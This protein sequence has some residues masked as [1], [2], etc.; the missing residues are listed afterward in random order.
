[1]DTAPHLSPAARAL[2]A[3]RLVVFDCDGVL[4]DTERIGPKVVAEMATEAG[5]PLTPAEV[6]EKFLGTSEPYLLAQVRAHATAP[7]PD[8]WLVEYRSRVAAAFDAAP[9]TMPGVVE[10]LDALDARS[11]PYCVA[12]SGSHPRIRHSLTATGLWERFAGRVF[13][14]D[15]VHRGKPAPDLFLHAAAACGVPPG[16][17]LVIEDSPAGVRAARA[18]HM[19]VLGYTGGPTPAPWLA[20]ASAGT[21]EDLRELTA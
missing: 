2:A 18:A 13:S 10:L 14:A 15:D 7:V 8:S 21:L 6:L 5:W 20:D 16:E 3:A 1:M 11:L 19:P 12:S 4:V 17:C 9:R